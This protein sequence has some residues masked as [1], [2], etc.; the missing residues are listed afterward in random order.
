MAGQSEEWRYQLHS[1]FTITKLQNRYS[2]SK[3]VV[4]RV[5]EENKTIELF[6]TVLEISICL[7][8]DVVQP[9]Q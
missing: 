7:D 9:A 6:Q 2:F 1:S 5:P 8:A 3:K 4:L